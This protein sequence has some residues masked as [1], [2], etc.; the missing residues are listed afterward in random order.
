MRKLITALLLAG[1]MALATAVPAFATDGTADDRA[2]CVVS[3][4]AQ[5][6]AGVFSQHFIECPR[7][8]PR[9]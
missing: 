8:G 5:E 4:R 2:A 3:D 1:L 7:V 9:P 6:P